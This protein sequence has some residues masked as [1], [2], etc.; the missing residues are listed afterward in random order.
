MK[1]TSKKSFDKASSMSLGGKK[2]Y[3]LLK[4]LPI[5]FITPI[6]CG[7]KPD[8]K[9]FDPLTDEIDSPFRYNNTS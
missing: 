5:Q 8:A 9:D 7:G 1:T 3:G 2:K 6:N 4:K